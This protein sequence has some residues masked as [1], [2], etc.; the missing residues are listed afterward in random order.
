M[1]FLPIS[2]EFQPNARSTINPLLLALKLLETLSFF[3][4]PVRL[5]PAL[6]RVQRQVYTVLDQ[7]VPVRL[8]VMLRLNSQPILPDATIWQQL[9]MVQTLA[10]QPL[11]LV[12]SGPLTLILALNV[13][14]WDRNASRTMALP[15]ILPTQTM[16]SAPE[17]VL[18]TQTILTNSI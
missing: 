10:R 4:K 9:L 18:L 8:I 6:L 7:M 13:P 3:T 16:S 12:I 11:P 1:Q 17:L 15:L 14:S 2:L 5:P